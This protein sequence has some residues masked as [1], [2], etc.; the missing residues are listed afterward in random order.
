MTRQCGGVGKSK[1]PRFP[2]A[3]AAAAATRIREALDRVAA[4]AGDLGLCG[5]ASGGDLLFAEACLE[6][7]MFLEVRLART[8]PEYLTESVTFADPDHRWEN[9]FMRSRKTPLLL[10]L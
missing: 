6:R 4:G 7:G 2:A 3:K 9:S 10:S 8:E 1:P 5:G